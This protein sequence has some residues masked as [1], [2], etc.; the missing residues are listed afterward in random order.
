MWYVEDTL[1]TD[2]FDYWPPSGYKTLMSRRPV[3][4][5]K[6]NLKTVFHKHNRIQNI[7]AFTIFCDYNYYFVNHSTR[8]NLLA[9]REIYVKIEILSHFGVG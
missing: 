1:L 8:P 9:I 2:Y 7:S 6:Y 4:N 3:V 5:L